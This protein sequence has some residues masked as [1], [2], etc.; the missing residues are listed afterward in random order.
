LVENGLELIYDKKMF[1]IS[2]EKLGMIGLL[3]LVG[4]IIYSFNLHNQLFW[5]DADWIVNN[6]TVHALGWDN[7]KFWFS[8]NTLAG[9]GMQSNYYRPFLFFTFAINYVISG[10]NPFSYHLFS[11]VIHI[12]NGLLIF[13][14]FSNVIKNKLVGFIAALLFL[15]HPIATEAV[16]YIAGR[17]DPLYV[18]FTLLGLWLFYSAE[19]KKLGWPGVTTS[20]SGL[21]AGKKNL[22]VVTP[23]WLSWQKI[24]S[25]VVLVLGLLSREVAI[26]FP[27]LALIFSIAFLETGTF[28]RSILNSLKRTWP[29]F[30]V[31]FVYGILRLTLLNFNNTLNF[32]TTP[33]IYSENL[34]VRL[35]TFM[36]ALFDY[37]GILF[38]PIKLHME[39]SVPIHLSPFD[40]PVWAVILLSA[41]A[42]YGL[43]RLYKKDRGERT[44][45]F[46]F[47][48]F[49]W[50]FVAL[51]PVSGITPINAQIYEH[52]L[53]LPAVAIFLAVGYGFSWLLNFLSTN[54]KGLRRLMVGTFALYIGWLS[55]QS[56]Q[57]N[58]VWGKPIEFYQDILTYEPDSVRINNNL[59][60]RYYDEG[61]IDR[62]EYYYQR[63]VES[64]DIFPQPH[65]NLGTILQARGD[66]HGAIE[67]Y[68]KALL[69]NP[70]FHY[71]YQNLAHLYAQQGDLVKARE[72][73]EQLEK[74][75]PNDPVT[76]Y[77]LAAVHQA[78]GNYVQARAYAEKGLLYAPPNS[79]VRQAL[80][81]ILTQL[82][83]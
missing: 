3:V 14:L 2:R 63:A 32:Y 71:P 18:F 37:F 65:Y 1:G 40:W 27:L 78:Q 56:I 44:F 54:R 26:V 45:R 25:L 10:V 42:I 12:I 52:W 81:E 64:E 20:S 53:Y 47:F 59:G 13:L 77:S 9:I 68:K 73:L 17:G 6:P 34:P 35:F 29:Y 75:R 82:N 24:V 67:E 30:G 21:I 50:F 57:R 11:N 15:V 28:I 39:R 5:D 41:G 31:V 19:S 7:I 16:T 33:N 58:I 72:L 70:Y 76:Y 23:G 60:N 8:H 80:E 36:H 66:N 55:Y 48:V 43:Y 4:A 79:K 74:I 51:G 49:G 46:W 62:A 22:E 61:N 83:K 38:V 69:I